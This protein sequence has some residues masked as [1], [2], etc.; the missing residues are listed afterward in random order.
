MKASSYAAAIALAL[1]A[2]GM[3]AGYAAE[4]QRNGDIA[5]AAKQAL[6]AE[7]GD[8]AKDIKVTVDKRGYATLSGWAQGPKD[9]SKARL[10]VRKV[11]GVNKA[12]SSRVRMLNATD[13]HQDK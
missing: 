3:S 8:R 10:I 13:E 6:T 4:S 5:V 7:M 1:A 12:F 2:L 11:P 9:V